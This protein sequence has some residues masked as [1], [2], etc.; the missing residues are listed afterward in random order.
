[1][2]LI[3][4]SLSAHEDEA[5]SSCTAEAAEEEESEPGTPGEAASDPEADTDTG[6]KQ[7]SS[8]DCRCVDGEDGE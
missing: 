3:E 1:M 8:T 5:G 7:M 2:R 4:A 6:D